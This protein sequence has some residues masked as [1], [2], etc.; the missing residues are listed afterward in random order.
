MD[1]LF[2]FLDTVLISK[3]GN[4]H[5]DRATI[6]ITII[7]AR[8]C[9]FVIAKVFVTER[10]FS[11]P[12]SVGADREGQKVRRLEGRKIGIQRSNQKP[13]TLTLSLEIK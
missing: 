5:T 10:A 6:T 2:L 1:K 8:V 12:N 13:R 3:Y 7:I 9:V 4:P 11:W